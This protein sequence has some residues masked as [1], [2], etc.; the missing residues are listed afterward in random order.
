MADI[1]A[2]LANSLSDYVKGKVKL[3]ALRREDLD[4]YLKINIE[5]HETISKILD[6]LSDAEYKSWF[7]LVKMKLAKE[8]S[9]SAKI[10]DRYVSSLRGEAA[11]KERSVPLKS[12]VK[13]NDEFANLLKEIRKKLDTVIEEEKVD[14]YNVR[15]STLAVL[16]IMKQSNTIIRFTSFLYSYLIKLSMDK[17]RG[18]PKYREAFLVEHVEE[19][20][21]IVTDVLGKKGAYLFMR[22]MNDLRQHQRDMVVGATGKFDFYKF[23]TTR[24]FS[25]SFLD[26]ILGALGSLN[27]FGAALDAWDDYQQDR[28][29]RNKEIKEWL[30]QHNAILRMDLQQMDPNSPEYQRTASIIE[31]YDAKIAEYDEAINKFEQED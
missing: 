5:S 6:G 1:F 18:I 2:T 12:L 19:A 10:Y 21:R 20:A 27:I 3:R 14:I 17:Q 16:G 24:G 28:Y 29:E 26:N 4:E 31:A 22:E 23:T 9:P 25:I 30:E 8:N 7:Q 11:S 15:L 13:V